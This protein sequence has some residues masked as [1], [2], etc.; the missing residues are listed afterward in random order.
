MSD[1]GPGKQDIRSLADQESLHRERLDTHTDLPLNVTVIAGSGSGET[2]DRK[3]FFELSNRVETR[4][5]DLVLCEDL[6]RIVRRI[7]AHIFAE[8]CADFET[9]LI[10]LNDNVD[11]AH[12]GW[13]DR[14]IFSARHHE[15]SNRD[16]SDRIKRTHRSRFSQGGVLPHLI[17]GYIKSPGAKS[18]AD[19]RKDPD[20]EP[21][22]DEWFARLERGD[23]F[24][25]IADWLNAKGVPTG[26]KRGNKRAKDKYDCALVG[27]RT[28]NPILKG[29]RE[30]S[31]RES[32]WVNSTGRRRSV[33]APPELKLDPNCP[34]IP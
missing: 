18:D 3:G 27:L 15:R 17:P 11:T 19:V 28:R 14:T 10:S 31:N 21:I 12:P 20:W 32:R 25:D 34:R 23:S 6:G 16:T 13:Q 30:R 26:C 33:K 5:Y 9:R 29:Q 7:H 8:L 1:T 22:Y 24:S 4:Q 2:L